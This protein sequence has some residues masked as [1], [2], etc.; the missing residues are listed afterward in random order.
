VRTPSL[1]LMTLFVGTV[2]GCAGSKGEPTT[3]GDGPGGTVKPVGTGTEYMGSAPKIDGFPDLPL[4]PHAKAVVHGNS[5]EI[6]FDPYPGAI[7]YRVY[8]K[9]AASSV[10]L[11]PDKS[12]DGVE[13]ATYRCAGHRAAP[14]IWVDFDAGPATEGSPDGVPNW[15]SVN[16]Q[17]ESKTA[18]TSRD[19]HGYARTLAD[20][21]LGQVFDV[22]TP[23]TVPI[24]AI[25]D[26]NPLADNYAFGVREPETRAKLYVTDKTQY[27]ASGWRDD[28]AAFYAPSSSKS[29]AC[30]SSAP[31]PI[32]ERDYT[33]ATSLA[34]VYY[35]D[36]SEANSRGTGKAAFYVCPQQV[37]AS[38]P[39]MR[40]YYVLAA[41]GGAFGN[42]DNSGH[43]ELVVGQERFDRARCQGSTFGPCAKAS[44]ARW[45]VHWSGITEKTELIVEALDAGCPFVGLF[46]AN[47]LAA[48]PVSQN[49]NNGDTSLM[50]DQ[51][52]TF[53]ELKSTAPHGEVY[54][55]G[56]FDGSPSPHPIARAL[57]EL[58]PQPRPAMQFASDFA[59]TPETFSE[60]FEDDGVTPKCGLTPTLVAQ[61]GT[62]DPQC[63]SSHQFTSASYQVHMSSI[64]DPRYSV[65]VT[66]GELW[67]GYSG[68]KFRI[69]SKDMTA[70][71]SDTSFLHV[72]MEASSFSTGR[73]YPQIM[74][75][76]QDLLTTQYLLER[77]P[78]DATN[79]HIQPVLVFNPID[80]G[81]GRHV[82]EIELCNNRGWQ[83][84]NHCP[85]FLLEEQNRTSADKLGPWAPHPELF[86]R[87]QDDRSVRYDLYVSTQKAYVFVDSQP[88]GC[89]DL[90][91]RSNKDKDGAP[92][93]PQPAPP[94]AGAVTVTFGDVLYHAGAEQG[95]YQS[96]SA[97]HLKHMLYETVRHFDYIGYNSGDP[98]PGWDEKAIPCVTGM[99]QGGGAGTQTP[100][101]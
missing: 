29:K 80:S 54:L 64:D 47:S 93:N 78:A 23:D 48:T 82:V 7:D 74:I 95:Y 27:V 79:S 83:V 89:V 62:A 90:A 87:F 38:K 61:S 3:P 65:G 94:K 51:I 36:G 12:F 34:H 86:D 18:K 100:E 72:A 5:A 88:Y 11:K 43:D 49:D 26:P 37:G 59:N 39:L 40:V 6:T 17:V 98:A 92:I 2:A 55:N 28:G 35:A 58:A 67:T 30:G 14:G 15:I 1:L 56:Q 52:F 81:V 4:L 97:F 31:V 46:G 25:G 96:Y 19:V 10:R 66:Q 53:D 8:V 13:D 44:Q 42:F 24:Y 50:T 70:T 32:Y 85:W 84:N 20:A 22:A 33:D 76:E 57:I 16:T 9:P 101:Q 99:H 91:H 73:R 60:L 45:G 69:T 71:V 68:G 41:P 75:S 63:D 21:A 77:T